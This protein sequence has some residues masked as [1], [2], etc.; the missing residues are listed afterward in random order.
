VPDGQV[1]LDGFV[2]AKMFCSKRVVLS[3]SSDHE[4][5]NVLKSPGV[6]VPYNPST[7]VE[8]EIPK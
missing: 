6:E 7:V 4:Q 3:D 8:N 1:Y 5:M 2:I